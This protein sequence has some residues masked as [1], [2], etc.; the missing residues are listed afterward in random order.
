MNDEERKRFN[1]LVAQVVVVRRAVAYLYSEAVSPGSLD[2]LIE[3]LDIPVF[4]DDSHQMQI[5]QA[6]VEDFVSD[7]HGFR[8][9][10]G[11]GER[12]GT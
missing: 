11:D 9:G 4:H 12:S 7:I 8:T 3:A 2:R 10:K 6:A 5:V 1:A